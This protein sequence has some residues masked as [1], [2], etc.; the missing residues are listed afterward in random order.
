[1]VRSTKKG[2]A[3][4]A[5]IPINPEQ[6]SLIQKHGA[7]QQYDHIPLLEQILRLEYEFH[8]KGYSRG[9]RHIQFRLQKQKSMVLRKNPILLLRVRFQQKPPIHNT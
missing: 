5:K 2:A 7:T 6:F 1:M 4:S 9:I 8:H 3:R